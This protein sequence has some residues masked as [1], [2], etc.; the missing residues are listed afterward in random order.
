MWQSYPQALEAEEPEDIKKKPLGLQ[1]EPEWME[2]ILPHIGSPT[3][4]DSQGVDY[5]LVRLLQ[6]A[7]A[8][9]GFEVLRVG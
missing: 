1:F 9:F 8:G 2:E 7:S 3:E 4:C 5:G 6:S